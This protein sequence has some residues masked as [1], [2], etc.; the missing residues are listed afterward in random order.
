M[1]KKTTIALPVSVSV[2]PAQAAKSVSNRGSGLMRHLS[3]QYDTLTADV[4]AKWNMA[5]NAVQSP[6]DPHNNAKRGA[7]G[8]TLFYTCNAALLGAGQP[9]VHTPSAVNMPVN[10]PPVRVSIVFVGS[11]P[12][13]TL[14]PNNAYPAGPAIALWATAAV[15]QGNGSTA[16]FKAKTYTRIGTLTGG[17]PA[18]GVSITAQYLSVFPSVPAS[19]KIGFKVMAVNPGGYRSVNEYAVGLTPMLSL[20]GEG[21]N[22][23]HNETL[24]LAVK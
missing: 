23:T 13:I 22:D 5:N 21:A 19:C 20:A 14:I 10:L 18:G 24:H 9:I 2:A 7:N 3:Q 15:P 4:K 12:T 17:L 1:T 16:A 8:W 11:T 6:G